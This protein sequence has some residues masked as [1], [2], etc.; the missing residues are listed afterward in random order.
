[1][2]GTGDEPDRQGWKSLSLPL[3]AQLVPS[4]SPRSSTVQLG[5][6]VL[7]ELAVVCRGQAC[8]CPGFASGLYCNSR[9]NFLCSDSLC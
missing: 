1:M 6:C 7:G 8:N 9:T 2:K 3:Q 5:V 4:D